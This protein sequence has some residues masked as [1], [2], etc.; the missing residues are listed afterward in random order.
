MEAH[1]ALP[2]GKATDSCSGPSGAWFRVSERGGGVVHL[3]RLCLSS[4]L[5]GPDSDSRR[6]TV[7]DVIASG[8]LGALPHGAWALG[9]ENDAL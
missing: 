5:P 3:R 6:L 4:E 9:T 8:R 2:A 7:Y 1:S